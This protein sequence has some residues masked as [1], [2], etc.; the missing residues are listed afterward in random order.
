MKGNFSPG[1][2]QIVCSC[3]N[4][5]CKELFLERINQYSNSVHK[6]ID[7]ITIPN[8]YVVELCRHFNTIWE[9]QPVMLRHVK[10]KNQHGNVELLYV[11]EKEKR[12]YSENLKLLSENHRVVEITKPVTDELQNTF[13]SMGIITTTKSERIYG[14]TFSTAHEQFLDDIVRR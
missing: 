12:L 9:N 3:L 8:A 13:N 4:K 1:N 14:H 2:T 7:S 11:F 6:H 5:V 10:S